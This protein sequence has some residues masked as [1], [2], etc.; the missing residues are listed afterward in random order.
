MMI[1]RLFAAIFFMLAATFAQADEHKLGSITGD[2][3]ELKTYD[4][5]IAG[6][7]R[8][9]VVWG[10]TNE[11][12]G[13]SQLIMRRDGQLV[14]TL[15]GKQGEKV[16]GTIEHTVAGQKV[17]TELYFV[18]FDKDANEYT[19]EKNGKP[20]KVKVEYEDFQNHHYINPTYTASLEDGS[21]IQFRFEGH[22][23]YNYSMHL[24]FL[25]VGAYSH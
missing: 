8:D 22:A 11:K 17:K 23:C 15:F 25:L 6:S 1:Q 7:I 10:F 13:V 4:H 24:I 12:N 14:N 20:F 18:G 21:Q 16:G 2:Q 3:I 9:F 5:A 19:F